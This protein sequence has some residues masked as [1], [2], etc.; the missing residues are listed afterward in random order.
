MSPSPELNCII[1]QQTY[2]TAGN[3]NTAFTLVRND[4]PWVESWVYQE[5]KPQPEADVSRLP[6]RHHLP[7]RKTKELAVAVAVTVAICTMGR[8]CS[9]LCELYTRALI[10]FSD[11]TAVPIPDREQYGHLHRY[12]ERDKEM[13]QKD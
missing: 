1:M 8:Q 3:T 9:G 11:V 13:R 4:Q 2:N 10:G 12:K 5:Y 6:R 7:V